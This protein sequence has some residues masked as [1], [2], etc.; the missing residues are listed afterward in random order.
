[1]GS[2][3]GKWSWMNCTIKPR[4]R[5]GWIVLDG[6]RVVGHAGSLPSALDLA[7][8]VV[9]ERLKEEEEEKEEDEV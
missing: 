4:N 1:M 8:A 9:A 3:V 5:V 7:A 2:V 6:E